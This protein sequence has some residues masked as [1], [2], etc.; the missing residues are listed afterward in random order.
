MD[1]DT[2]KVKNI[3]NITRIPHAMLEK[4]QLKNQVG[5]LELKEN[6]N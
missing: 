2:V 3:S 1:T 6:N 4:T 5:I